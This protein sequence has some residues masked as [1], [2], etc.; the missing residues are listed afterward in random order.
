[1]RPPGTAL[2]REFVYD[3]A[4][5]LSLTPGC[6]PL[7]AVRALDAGELLVPLR[8]HGRIVLWPLFDTLRQI[9]EVAPAIGAR[10]LFHF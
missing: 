10:P 3:S 6:P 5:F 7:V 4:F 9:V 1:V 8:V 2:K